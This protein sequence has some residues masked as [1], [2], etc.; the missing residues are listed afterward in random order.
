MKLIRSSS[1][2]C[3]ALFVLTLGVGSTSHADETT[4]DYIIQGLQALAPVLNSGLYQETAKLDE[5]SK[6]YAAYLDYQLKEAEA[7]AKCAKEDAKHPST[8]CV[9]RQKAA[10]AAL[11]AGA[12]A[13]AAWRKHIEDECK[14]AGKTAVIG[15]DYA[16][17]QDP[18]P[19]AAADPVKKDAAPPKASS[20]GAAS[21]SPAPAAKATGAR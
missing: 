15:F 21:K 11:K 3:S 5:A 12:E 8:F 1:L 20:A 18:A 17:C 4:G 9:D 14:K 2:V 13:W 7:D 16:F 19:Q 6:Q 10:A